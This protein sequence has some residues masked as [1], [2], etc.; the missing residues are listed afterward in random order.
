MKKV[1]VDNKEIGY[2]I[3]EPTRGRI[4]ESGDRLD[5]FQDSF[6]DLKTLIVGEYI[7]LTFNKK[8]FTEL[9]YKTLKIETFN[10]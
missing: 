7:S 6:A 3:I 2:L 5:T 10:S 4:I 8:V 1:T 9:A